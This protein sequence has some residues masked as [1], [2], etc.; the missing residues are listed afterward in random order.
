MGLMT[1][2]ESPWLTEEQ[3]YAWRQW[4]SVNAELPTALHR[5]LQADARLSYPDF[6][7]LVQLTDAPAGRVRVSE[8]ATALHWERSRLSHHIKRMEARGL[9]AR[10]ECAGD[11]RGAFVVIT[12]AGRDA[13]ERAAP[14]HAR[15]VKELVFD[16]LTPNE[17]ASLTSMT[18]KVLSRLRSGTLS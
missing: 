10:E 6:E 5:A 9:V 12:A 16:S 4:L 8:L 7:V 13:I 17:L 3:Q 15:R 2:T 14:D 11:G 18:D 1:S